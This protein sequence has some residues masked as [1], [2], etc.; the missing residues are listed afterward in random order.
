[1]FG[2]KTNATKQSNERIDAME[3]VVNNHS[4]V[5][6]WITEAM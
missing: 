4:S 1:M 5:L 6:F 3:K 2:K